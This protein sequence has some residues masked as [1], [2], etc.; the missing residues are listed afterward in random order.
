MV[1]TQQCHVLDPG[2]LS[3]S[4]VRPCCAAG[5]QRGFPSAES[6]CSRESLRRVD[7]VAVLVRPC[8]APG[9]VSSSRRGLFCSAEGSPTSWARS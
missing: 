6:G 2:R 3:Q 5:L 7:E 8:E 1:L 9:W 4:G